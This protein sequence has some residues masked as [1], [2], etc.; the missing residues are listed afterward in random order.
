MMKIFS[1]FHF[2]NA[3]IKQKITRFMLHH[4]I[5]QFKIIVCKVSFIKNVIDVIKV[6]HPKKFK[7]QHSMLQSIHHM[8]L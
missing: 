8:I 6:N 7:K 5:K 1:V 3:S 2:F 4:L